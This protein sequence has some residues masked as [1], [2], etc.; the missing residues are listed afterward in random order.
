MIDPKTPYELSGGER[1]EVMPT[2]N[3]GGEAQ[4]WGAAVIATE[5]LVHRAGV[6]VG[7]TPEP[8]M[9]RAPDVSVIPVGPSHGWVKSVP[10]LAIE[11]ADQGQDEPSLQQKIA[12]L[13]GAGTL[14]IWVVRLGLDQ[15]VEVYE[16]GRAMRVLRPGEELEAPGIV[17]PP[18]RVEAL[19]DPQAALP[20]LANNALRRMGYGDGIQ[21]IRDEGL[22]AGR[23]AGIAEGKAEGK[24]EGKTEGLRSSI[25]RVL[26]RRG[27]SLSDE[28]A[29]R[30]A[31]EVDVAV[32]EG[33]LDAVVDGLDPFA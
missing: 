10:P 20:R 22:A 23:A 24:T 1:I 9:L 8:G 29:A 32:L 21:G 7:Y 31:A 28:G 25:G 27:R 3:R 6:D 26:R 33:W 11:Y 18:L 13:L 4:T 2:G 30:L 15:R 12:D 16:P 17:H 14:H 5:P 19:F